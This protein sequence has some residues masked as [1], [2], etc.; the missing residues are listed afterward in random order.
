MLNVLPHR[1]VGQ[2]Q[3]LTHAADILPG[4]GIMLMYRSTA[5]QPCREWLRCFVGVIMHVVVCVS[6]CIPVVLAA[7]HHTRAVNKQG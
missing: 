1:E 2:L 4:S 5:V 7:E 6:Y 3:T